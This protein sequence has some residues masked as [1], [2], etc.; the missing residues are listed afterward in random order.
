MV[1]SR[2]L[3]TVAAVSALTP[4]AAAF[5]PSASTNLAVYYVGDFMLGLIYF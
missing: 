4:F 3:A 5:D 2:F 1:S